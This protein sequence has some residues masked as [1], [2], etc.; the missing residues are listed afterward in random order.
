M[1]EAGSSR[2]FGHA[3]RS[4]VRRSCGMFCDARG[5]AEASDAVAVVR[6]HQ[7]VTTVDTVASISGKPQT[8]RLG[9]RNRP[10]LNLAGGD[11]GAAAPIRML[12]TLAGRIG[13]TRIE[14]PAMIRL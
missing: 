14:G 8:G 5:H 1:V 7:L 10:S 2:S 9:L 3:S 12:I 11:V 6:R 4:M 13:W